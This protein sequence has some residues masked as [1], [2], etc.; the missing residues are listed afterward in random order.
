IAIFIK[1]EIW[2]NYLNELRIRNIPTLL[3]SGIFNKR[4]V[5]F[6]WYG[7]FM[8]KTLNSF[9]H[10]FVQEENSKN[11]LGSIGFKNVSISGDTRFDRV[12][13]ILQQENSLAFMDRFKGKSKCFVAGSTWPED[14]KL[15]LD[16]INQSP[17]TLK[18][19]LAPHNIK[20]GNIAS[21][22]SSISKKVALYSEIPKDAILDS[23]VLIV[24]A[25]GLL[26]QIY[27]Y[28][29]FAYV[30]GGFATGLHN[31]L[32]PAVFGIPV[33][34]GPNYQG[35]NEAV[36]MVG[37]GGL[38]VVENKNDFN[39]IMER[40]IKEPIFAEKTGRNNSEYISENTGAT[41]TVIEHIETLL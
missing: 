33:I 3:V 22:K 31:T 24:D 6:K 32:E 17:G 11:L 7:G 14:E 39:Q 23:E 12:F 27:S 28:A 35:F 18:F 21:L 1:Y 25:I 5:F 8:K 41:E 40:F 26:T 34:I 36:K 20:A 16:F 9:S 13:E 38:W 10:F 19:V 37:K 4:Q 30:G 2:P 29:D 15:L